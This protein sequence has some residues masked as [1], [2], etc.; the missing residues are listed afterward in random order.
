LGPINLNKSFF[1]AAIG[2]AVMCSILVSKER[3]IQANIEIEW[4]R[5]KETAQ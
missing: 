5:K 1:D 2:T 4:S 3:N